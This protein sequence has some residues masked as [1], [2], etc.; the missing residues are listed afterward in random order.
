MSCNGHYQHMQV[1][2]PPL[3]EMLKFLF[4][5]ISIQPK[6]LIVRMLKEMGLLI[7]WNSFNTFV[8]YRTVVDYGEGSWTWTQPA[9]C[10]NEAGSQ[11]D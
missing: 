1:Q 3:K 2:G 8:I 9:H 11:N 6:V 10:Q 5:K 4:H 7:T